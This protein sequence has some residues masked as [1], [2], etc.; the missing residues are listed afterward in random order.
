MDKASIRQEMR[1]KR[2]AMSAG[3]LAEKSD[4][5]REQCEKLL[6]TLHFSRIHCYRSETTWNEPDTSWVAEVIT[7]IAPA[8]ELVYGDFAGETSHLGSFDLI[9]VPFLAFDE[10]LNRVGFGSGWYDRFLSQHPAACTIGFGYEFQK[11]SKVPTE[12][13]DLPLTHVVT[14]LAIYS[15]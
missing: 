8:S 11:V 15:N 6:D 7:K 4:H 1:A 2:R 5:I 14:E 9:I 10:S 13:H 12:P 3:E